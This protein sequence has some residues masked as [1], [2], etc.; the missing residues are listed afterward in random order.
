LGGQLLV[1]LIARQGGL[2]LRQIFS[3]DVARLVFALLPLLEL[4]IRAVGSGT[5]LK[6]ISGEF[7][8]LHGWDGGDLLEDVSVLRL[9]HKL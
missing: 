9:V 1:L 7:A 3:R 6:R 2:N 5:V 4:V 8:A